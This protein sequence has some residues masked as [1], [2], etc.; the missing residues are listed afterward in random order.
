MVGVI[1]LIAAVLR[2]GF[3]VDAASEPVVIGL[4]V[5]VGLTIAASQ[6]PKLLG[7]APPDESGFYTS[8]TR[9]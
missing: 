6:L 8:A 2:L 4:K 1:L 9:S 7:I 3:L 5:G